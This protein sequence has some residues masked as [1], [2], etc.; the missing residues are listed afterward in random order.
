MFLRQLR[1]TATQ[2]SRYRFGA[3]QNRGKATTVSPAGDAEKNQGWRIWV[4][5]QKGLWPVIAV[6]AMTVAYGIYNIYQNSSAPYW[7]TDRD[8]R[9][10]IDYLE[11]NKD[12]KKAI[13]WRNSTL[14]KGPEI[15]H[16][17]NPY[18]K[19]SDYKP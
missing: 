13:K 14:E 17:L 1:R 10:T 2:E 15:I 8:E 9:H 7:K 6:T 11:N 12:P 19:A 4:S 5:E 18:P 16:K 3:A